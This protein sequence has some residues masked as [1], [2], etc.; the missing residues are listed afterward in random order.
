MDWDAVVIGAGPAGCFTAMQIAKSGYKVLIIEEHQQ[1]GR[2]V[3]CS[4]L[5]S[6]RAVQLAGV[7]KSLVINRLTE[8]RVLSPLG[9]SLHV[10][11]NRAL[12]L[13]IDRAAFDEDLA[14]KAENAGAV[15]L[16]GIKAEAAERISGGFRLTASDK[17]KK[18]ITVDT[19]IMI[20]ADGVNSK[21]AEWLALK[22]NH[23]KAVMFAAD[24]KLKNPDRGLISIFLGR[25]LAPGWFGWIIPLDS[26]TCRI[27]TGYALVRPEY[28]PQHYFQLL[29]NHYPQ[30]FKDYKMIRYTGGI[31][32]L[33]LMPRIY[34]SNSMLVGD[35]ACQT[36]PIS[37]GGI[38]MG[39]RGAQI[40]GKTAVEALNEDNL[41]EEKMSSYQTLWEKE[42]AEEINSSM[43]LRESFLD[44]R[45]EDIDLI[46]R[47]LSRP[48]CQ[49]LILKYGDID[50]PSHIAS[51]LISF[52]PW[53]NS[54]LKAVLNP[55]DHTGF[56]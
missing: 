6:P 48:K 31:V 43:K 24:V 20:G 29:T 30:I 34:A 47:F 17:N 7:D 26:E 51:K 50:Y 25:D 10:K 35:A 54:L 40:C 36:K 8:L 37:G 22:R 3:Q 12:A 5:I 53:K 23:S 52:S 49:N 39:L 45:D 14:L 56:I 2:P 46:I 42:I 41:S 27:G 9:S 11:S 4:G 16:K 44:F 1:I 32:P 33:G 21:V 55:T 28:S 18:N 38:Y 19:K 13:A 15:L